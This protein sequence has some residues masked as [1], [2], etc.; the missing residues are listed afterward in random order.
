MRPIQPVLSRLRAT[1]AA[2]AC[3]VA[4]AWQAKFHR[5]AS[6]MLA[7]VW[8]VNFLVVLPVLSPDFVTLLAYPVTLISKLMF[9]LA[10]ARSLEAS[11]LAPITLERSG[12]T[13]RPGTRRPALPHRETSA[14]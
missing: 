10:A 8:A 4:A 14:G 1:A 13:R 7:A 5:L 9:G 3:A 2:L 6:L 12:S 11:P